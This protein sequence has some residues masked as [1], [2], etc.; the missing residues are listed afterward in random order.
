MVDRSESDASSVTRTANSPP[1]A[2]QSGATARESLLAAGLDAL[3]SGDVSIL[4]NGFSPER[5]GRAA[6]V[7]R[8]TFYHLFENK[9]AYIRALAESLVSA[10]PALIGRDAIQGVMEASEGD[11]ASVI[12]A[13][14]D[15]FWKQYRDEQTFMPRLVLGE[16]G[17]ADRFV[18]D[19]TYATQRRI[20]ELYSP[21][22]TTLL[23]E[24]GLEF[25]EGWDLESFILVFDAL[26]SGLIFR[27]VVTPGSA[28]PLVQRASFGLFVSAI[29]FVDGPPPGLDDLVL[30]DL[31]CSEVS[32]RWLT[33][34][35]DDSA[36]DLRQRIRTAVADVAATR[37]LNEITFGI[38]AAKA[39]T[40]EHVVAA[41]GPVY[42]QICECFA[43]TYQ[44]L[45]EEL[46]LDALRP[47]FDADAVIDRHRA[48]IKQW[49]EANLQLTANFLASIFA[50]PGAD[51]VL[52][53][54]AAVAG[55]LLEALGQTSGSGDISQNS[56]L[57]VLLDC[58]VEPVLSWNR[59]A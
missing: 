39:G 9:R 43:E 23:D 40:S 50:W 13:F 27:D 59:L 5:I 56:A 37:P 45:N 44:P 49:A 19:H 7:S 38:L 53:T 41:A 10:E 52:A 34:N 31:W 35:A 46:G 58:L 22:W 6:G 20:V 1:V 24:W 3:C 57:S 28:D 29:T 14:L 2:G 21:M 17:G 16:L 51:A 33:R 11:A 47:E 30:V 18:A 42:Q 25:R 32:R 36:I 54:R 15:Q 55:P 12:A 26:I 4:E 48:R 8:R